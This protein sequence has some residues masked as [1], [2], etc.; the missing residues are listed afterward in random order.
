MIRLR[1]WDGECTL[2]VSVLLSYMG[3]L[4]LSIGKVN[5][6]PKSEEQKRPRESW[7][8]WGRRDEVPGGCEMALRKATLHSGGYSRNVRAEC[9]TRCFVCTGTMKP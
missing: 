6:D 5:L 7:S 3:S 4:Q 9:I 2:A 1:A 8:H